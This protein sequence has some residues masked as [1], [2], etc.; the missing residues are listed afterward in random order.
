M[1]RMNREIGGVGPDIAPFCA[2]RGIKD[3]EAGRED[4]A[5]GEA[6]RDVLVRGGFCVPVAILP[7]KEKHWSAT[8]KAIAR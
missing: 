8:R 5:E 4:F 6:E 1:R 7:G 3:R 2:G